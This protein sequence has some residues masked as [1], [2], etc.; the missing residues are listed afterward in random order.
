M[1]KEKKKVEN[2]D[3]TQAKSPLES[4]TQHLVQQTASLRINTSQHSLE[5]RRLQVYRIQVGTPEKHCHG[6][7]QTHR[8]VQ[9]PHI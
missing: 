7:D 4:P 2:I 6:E 9:V 8:E 5:S 1:R 3:E